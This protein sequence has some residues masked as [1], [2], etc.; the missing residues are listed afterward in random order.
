MDRDIRP[1]R[2]KHGIDAVSVAVPHQKVIKCSFMEC[3]VVISV[4]VAFT[5]IK[6]ASFWS[7]YKPAMLA[8]LH[9]VAMVDRNS[10]RHCC[11]ILRRHIEDACMVGSAL[12]KKNV[13]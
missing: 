11:R 6:S 8:L 1:G 4:S 5:I 9:T 13:S 3:M 7:H 2:T 12:G 10:H